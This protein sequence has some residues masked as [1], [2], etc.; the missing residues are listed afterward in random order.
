M[1]DT[2]F[3]Q[4]APRCGGQR[5]A[6]EELCCQLARRMAPQ[7]ATFTRLHGAAGDGGVEC[8]ADLPNGDRIGWQAKYVSDID[9]LLRQ[10]TDSLT[11][12]L[13]IHPAL[14]RYILCFPFDLTGP[15]GRRGR[16][17]VQ[18]FEA[19]REGQVRRAAGLGRTLEIEDWPAAR[20]RSLLMELDV[21][22]GISKFFFDKTL[23]STEWFADHLR[24][25]KATADPRYTPELNVRTDVRKWFAAFGRTTEWLHGLEERLREAR[26]RRNRLSEA[27]AHTSGDPAW[28]EWPD[29]IREEAACLSDRLGETL[30]ACG[31]LK[32]SHDEGTHGRSVELLGNVLSDLSLL[33]TKLVADLEERHGPGRADSP[34]FR[35]FMAEY[36]V[37]L[38]AA[39][40]D[41]V[42][43][44]LDAFR[45]LHQWLRSPEGSL[46]F[47]CAFVLSG[48]WG[49]GKTHGVCDVS[50]QRLGQQLLSCVVFG[51]QFGGEPDLWT[52]LAESLGLPI[53]LGKDGLLDALNAAA[54]ASGQPL[55]LFID[56]IN[57]TRP[58]QYWRNRL[59][60]VVEE[61]RR[62]PSLRIC[63]TC[64]TPYL[65]HCLPEAHGLPAVEHPGFK[66]VEQIACTA[67]FEH[68]RLKPP[69]APILQPELGNPLYLRLVC[70]TLRSR[71]IDELP[72]GWS[73]TAQVISAFLEEKEKEFARDKDVSPNARIVTAS[74]RSIA[75]AIVESGQ[76]KLSWSEASGAIC[77]TRP[78]V[79]TLG[80]VEWLVRA[81][82]LIEEAPYASAGFPPESMVRPA[83]ERLGDSLIASE[84]LTR[85][86]REASLDSAFDAGGQLHPW[87]QDRTAVKENYGV[88]SALSILIPE[89]EAGRELP[90]L[91]T[92]DEVRD[93]LLEI[94]VTSIPWRDPRSFSSTTREVVVKAL[95]KPELC[96]IATDSLMSVAWQPSAIDATWLHELLSGIPFARRDAHWCG[97][98]H[99]SY[100]QSGP[101]RR[102]IDA[103]FDL[104]LDTL[105]LG[106]A[107]RWAIALLWFTAAADRR[108]KDW[109]TRAL[110]R[111]LIARPDVIPELL[112]RF[113]HVDDDEVRERLLL[114]S[115]GALIIS[116]NTNVTKRVTSTLQAAFRDS[117]QDFHN[118]LIRDHVRCIS[119]LTRELNILSEDCDPQLTMRPIVS[120]WPLELP[121]E[122]QVEEWGELLRFKLSEFFSDFFK[123]SMSCLRPWEHAF[124]RGDMGKWIIQRVARDFGYEGSGCEDYDRY[125]LSK[126]G[127]GRGKPAWVERIGK[128]YQW[129]AMY[130][131]ASRLHDHVTR[132]FDSWEP[133]PLRTPLILLEERKLD[134]TLLPDI[135]EGKRAAAWWITA[136]ADLD[137]TK[138]LSDEEW[139]AREE[140]VPALEKLLSIVVRDGQNWRL[141]VS[142]PSWGQRS[143]DADWNDPYRQVWMHIEGYLVQKKDFAIA[144]DCLHRRN[145]FG[146]WMP[147]GA[148]WLYGF[149]SEY[150]WA[151]A[152]NTEPEEWHG[153]GG[154][155]TNLPVAFQP[156]WNQIA[157]EWE[158]DASLPRN[159]HM[160]VPARAFFSPSDLWGDG[161]H[162]YRLVSGR[163]VFRDPSLRQVGTACLLADADDLLERLDKLGLRLVWTLLGEKGIL[164]GPHDTHTPR[165]T[166]SQIVCL[167]EDGSLHVGERVFFDDYQQ[168]T[169]PRVIAN[170]RINRSG[171]SR[172]RRGPTNRSSGRS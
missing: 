112:A 158:Y 49:V 39:N 115:Y 44:V 119:E 116:R 89:H 153:R 162:G 127:G 106:V 77:K 157:V 56:A 125:M 98:L 29:S 124:P 164:G 88:L 33:E 30:D 25:A 96:Q 126:Y 57:E 100:E 131:I 73:S 107:E 166:F 123:Y 10:G 138:T 171:T 147:E 142:Y 159:F 76:S 95:R 26:K 86:G 128:K 6:F 12:A 24:V 103:A 36:E 74:L 9:S 172:K 75:R 43:E 23:L 48:G 120:E 168:D 64:R 105:E 113:L 63:F 22:G 40:L 70:E 87:V 163:T 143:E 46:A 53:T 3:Q 134:P 170:A 50:C 45:N 151:T 28:P 150:P 17:N 69:V 85:L 5:E 2:Y 91:V 80:V 7:D 34:G 161:Q 42:R 83:F 130:Q 16:S 68:Y 140:D 144:Y 81:N 38:P 154:P 67:F 101:V 136:S 129:I 58:L 160:L 82:L 145:F 8:F 52:R 66:G 31:T 132:E 109:A 21:S 19:W 92:S 90:E 47:C 55:I 122:D 79:S 99:Q 133:A 114:A 72:T 93:A 78:E 148:T 121:S 167:R 108:I 1:R 61:I 60:A 149:A 84:L 137:V 18:K 97:Y 152:F 13:R 155:G 14:T 146:R 156:S 102:L 37:S 94:V 71:G 135:C 62:R 59:A 11:T 169:G 35:Q 54:E 4:I 51:H 111:V 65:S 139:V 41:T 104:P 110:I 20:L 15:T 165:R 118:A 32:E 141:L 27:I 117:P